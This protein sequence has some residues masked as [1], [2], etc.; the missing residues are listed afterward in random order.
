MRL[1]NKINILFFISLATTIISIEAGEK[2]NWHW[3]SGQDSGFHSQP[4]QPSVRM[5]YY[6]IGCLSVERPYAPK[7]PAIEAAL[8]SQQVLQKNKSPKAEV[9]AEEK[10]DN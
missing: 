10:Q 8:Q 9:K 5:V 1:S 7:E 6:R 4:Q 2:S 3:L